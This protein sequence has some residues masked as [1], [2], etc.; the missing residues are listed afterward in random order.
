MRSPR[1]RAVIAWHR[2]LLAAGTVLA[3]LVPGCLTIDGGAI[4]L[5]W[6]PYCASGKRP[7]ATGASCSCFERAAGLATVQLVLDGLGDAAVGD[8]CAG[9]A[10]CRFEAKRQSGN[11]G[12]FVPPGDYEL[13]LLP[14]DASGHVLGGPS[15]VPD[16]S[17][18]S[19]W[20][21]PTP[22]RRT[23]TTGEVVS[24][25]SFLIAVPDCPVTPSCAAVDTCPST[26]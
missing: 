24:L 25:G 4:E 12:F 1:H 21:T 8:A 2:S 26:P 9:R 23:V 17:A 7:G 22:V 18:A 14:L 13:T 6:V 11:T 5:S 20:Q 16:G 10:A 19:C 15:C 3:A